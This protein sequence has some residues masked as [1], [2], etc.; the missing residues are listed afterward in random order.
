MLKTQNLI[1]PHLAPFSEP[2]SQNMV[3]MGGLPKM[4]HVV[5]GNAK[6]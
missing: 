4:L 1:F 2:W 3:I 6:A 5:D